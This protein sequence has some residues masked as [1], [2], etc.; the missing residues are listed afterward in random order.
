VH[1]CAAVLLRVAIHPR[2]TEHTGANNT[3]GTFTG[4]Q[5]SV[6]MLVCNL[7]VAGDCSH[8]LSLLMVTPCLLQYLALPRLALFCHA[9]AQPPDVSAAAVLSCTVVMTMSC[10]EVMC[11]AS[12][13]QALL[14]ADS[15]V[16]RSG[17]HSL[18]VTSAGK[19]CRDLVSVEHTRQMHY[20]PLTLRQA[21]VLTPSMDS[22]CR[23]KDLL[24]CCFFYDVFWWVMML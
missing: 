15:A 10:M 2:L 20:I 5:V 4:T 17:L 22:A 3:H 9:V 8:A 11:S 14:S 19:Y 13:R 1:A 24:T 6:L 12:T 16:S 21:A 18:Q 7:S 23:F